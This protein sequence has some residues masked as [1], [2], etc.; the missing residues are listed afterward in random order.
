MVRMTS[1]TDSKGR[2]GACD[3]IL[4]L[5][6]L[7]AD[8]NDCCFQV[9]PHVQPWM[10]KAHHSL[11]CSLALAYMYICIRMTNCAAQR[12]HLTD[13][14]LADLGERAHLISDAILHH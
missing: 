13:H 8:P 2:K 14:Q 3:K 4:L 1:T 9:L 10:Q 12:L 7:I 11:S 5:I 6:S